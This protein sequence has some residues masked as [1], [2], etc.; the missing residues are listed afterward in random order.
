M[1]ERQRKR[2]MAEK[3]NQNDGSIIGH[4][5]KIDKNVRNFT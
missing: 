2:K 3:K 4:E 1:K 5:R